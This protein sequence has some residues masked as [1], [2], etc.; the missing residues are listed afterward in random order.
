MTAIPESLFRFLGRIF[1]LLGV[2]VVGT[3][4]EKP[5]LRSDTAPET[6][7]STPPTKASVPASPGLPPPARSAGQPTS[8]AGPSTADTPP[9]APTR[10]EDPASRPPPPRPLDP[11][12][13][14]REYTRVQQ[15]LEAQMLGIRGLESDLARHS[16]TLTQLRNQLQLTRSRQAGAGRGGI[17]VERINGQ[18]TLIDRKAEAR[19]LEKQ[20]SAVEPLVTQLST[21]LREARQQYVELSRTAENLLKE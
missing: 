9:V 19:E 5:K 7:E 10:R 15:K 21:A 1:F 8:P 12:A 4:C 14:A 17:R 16:A 2:L 11:A 20:I 13:R 18:S 6:A 3:G